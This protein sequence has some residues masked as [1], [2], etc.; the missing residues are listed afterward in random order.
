MNYFR[1]WWSVAAILNN[2]SWCVTCVLLSLR[3]GGVSVLHSVW[4]LD[5]GTGS[6]SVS[7]TDSG[8]HQRHLLALLQLILPQR[9][10]RVWGHAALQPGH[11][12]HCGQR[13]PGGHLPLVTGGKTH[14]QLSGQHRHLFEIPTWQATHLLTRDTHITNTMS[15]QYFT[16]LCPAM[17]YF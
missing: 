7:R 9:R 4:G 2:W 8:C 14:T 10:R 15:L 6:G 17:M 16:H 13:Q 1:P 3:R 12:G 11:R 5:C